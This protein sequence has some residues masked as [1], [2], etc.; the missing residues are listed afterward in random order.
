MECNKKVKDNP[1]CLDFP[2]YN[3]KQLQERQGN[4]GLNIPQAYN[5]KEVCYQEN[6]QKN[7]LHQNCYLGDNRREW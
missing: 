6:S 4:S 2:M 1:N 3:L 7:I 5:I